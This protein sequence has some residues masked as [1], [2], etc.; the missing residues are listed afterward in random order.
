MMKVLG[1]IGLMIVLFIVGSAP[2]FAVQDACWCEWT[3]ECEKR[4]Q[5]SIEKECSYKHVCCVGEPCAD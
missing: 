4:F 2:T 1:G 3:E 5:E